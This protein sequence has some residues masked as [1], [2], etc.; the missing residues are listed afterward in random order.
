M[1]IKDQSLRKL[2]INTFPKSKKLEND[3]TATF[4]ALNFDLISSPPV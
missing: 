1:L 4:Q 3:L 2:P